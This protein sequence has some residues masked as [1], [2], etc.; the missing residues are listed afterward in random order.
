[1][2][3]R[4]LRLGG[5]IV[6]RLDRFSRGLEDLVARNSGRLAV[7]FEPVVGFEL[8]IRFELGAVALAAATGMRLLITQVTSFMASWILESPG[9]LHIWIHHPRLITTKNRPSLPPLGRV[10][11]SCCSAEST[12]KSGQLVVSLHS[13]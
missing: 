10:P 9:R 1:M 2:R 11:Q 4:L 12:S 6:S 13:G 5:S 3:A 8:G 7:E